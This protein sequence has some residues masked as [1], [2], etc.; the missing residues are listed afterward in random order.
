MNKFRSALNAS[1]FVALSLAFISIAQAQTTRTW[2][3]GV[4]DDVNSCSRTAPC[5]TFAGAIAK[6]A[7]GGEINAIDSGGYGTVVITKSI[8]IDGTGTLAGILAANNTTGVTI[9]ITNPTDAQTV[10]LRGLAINGLGT[11][12][13]GILVTSAGKVSIED[14]VI[15]GF[16]TNGV[17]VRSG[18]VFITN[19]TIRNNVDAGI[20]VSLIGAFVAVSDVNMIFNGAGFVGDVTTYHDVVLYGNKSDP[21]PPRRPLN[22]SPRPLPPG[23]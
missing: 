3:S 6:T 2:V 20:N 11:G 7:A 5:K 18:Q 4:G 9:N 13:Q 12:L 16:K 14:V 22:P 19:T 23:P 1:L 8:T 15:D 10:R 17:S 21:Q